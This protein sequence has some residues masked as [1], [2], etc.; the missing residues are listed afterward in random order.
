[1]AEKGRAEP[2]GGV[3]L[4]LEERLAPVGRDDLDRG[5]DVGARGG[6]TECEG[7]R[8]REQLG[9]GSRL[10]G[11]PRVPERA[12]PAVVRHERARGK[13]S[14]AS[15]APHIDL[16]ELA[17]SLGASVRRSDGQLEIRA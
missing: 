3:L 15:S 10:G 7:E 4:L 8:S 9:K 13:W 17:R 14:S 12:V 5:N 6:T 1:M 2:F 11:R 16:V